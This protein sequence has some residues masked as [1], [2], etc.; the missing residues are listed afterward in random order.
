ME[1]LYVSIGIFIIGLVL[2]IVGLKKEKLTIEKAAEKHRQHIEKLTMEQ[3]AEYRSR[4]IYRE[5]LEEDIQRAKDNREIAMERTAEAQ[6]ATQQLLQSEQR[7]LAAELQRR[8][9]LD[10]VRFEQEK[11]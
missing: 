1:Y 2:F 5:A 10:E 11:D 9:E 3:E 7:R 6:A 8:K 4:C